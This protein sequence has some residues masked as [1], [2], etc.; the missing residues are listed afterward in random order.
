MRFS[1]HSTRKTN[2]ICPHL[3]DW[4]GNAR[5]LCGFRADRCSL[6]YKHKVDVHGY[7]VGQQYALDPWVKCGD[8]MLSEAPYYFAVDGEDVDNGNAPQAQPAPQ[9]DA[10]APQAI[11]GPVPHAHPGAPPANAM[12]QN[13]PPFAGGPH[14]HAHA[15]AHYGHAYPY[16][17]PHPQLPPGHLTLNKVEVTRITDEFGRLV[18]RIEKRT[19]V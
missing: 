12:N 8:I 3:V 15:Y 17:H 4:E 11:P 7:N 9:N 14:V 13:V 10:P 1:I 19:Y 5:E 18:Q 16:A 2:W 6:L